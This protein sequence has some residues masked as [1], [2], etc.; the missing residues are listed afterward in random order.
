MRGGEFPVL[1]ERRGLTRC[2]GL[3]L[4]KKAP[5]LFIFLQ[6]CN[7]ADAVGAVGAAERRAG[8]TAAADH[9]NQIVGR[10]RAVGLEGNPWEF[11]PGHFQNPAALVIRIAAT[12]VFY[13]NQH[14]QFKFPAPPQSW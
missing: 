4:Q 10:I 3:A 5:E 7:I 11:R 9:Q 6:T 2:R 12:A 8:L 13:S 14:T 1:P